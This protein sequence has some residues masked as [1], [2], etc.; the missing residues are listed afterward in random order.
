[1]GGDD[2]IVLDTTRLILL[3]LVPDILLTVVFG[4]L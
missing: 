4:F 2:R 3:L 1:M